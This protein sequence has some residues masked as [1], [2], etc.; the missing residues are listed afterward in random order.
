[1]LETILSHLTGSAITDAFVSRMTEKCEA[2]AA[3]HQQYIAATNRLHEELGNAVNEEMDAINRQ[4]ASDLLFAGF[5]GLKANLDHFIDP[6]A[7]TFLDVDFGV[8]LQEETAHSLPEYVQ[9]QQLR[10]RFYTQ[11][12]P[13]QRETYEAVISYTSHLETVGPKLA[14]Y[15][16]YLLGNELLPRVIPGYHTDT[17][18]TMRY[19]NMLNQYFGTSVSHNM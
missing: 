16:G 1:M 12:T 8:Y 19:T 4:C 9:A 11:L 5:L 2:F 18:L 17:V 15:Y 10:D 13:A 3:D 6:V 7:R 14:H